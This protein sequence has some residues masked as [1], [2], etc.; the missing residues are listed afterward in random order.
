MYE[1]SVSMSSSSTWPKPDGGKGAGAAMAVDGGAPAAADSAARGAARARAEE[2]EAARQAAGLGL[3]APLDGAILSAVRLLPPVPRT[4]ARAVLLAHPLQHRQVTAV[5]RTVAS[6]RVPRA[7][8]RPRPE[9]RF[10]QPH[11]SS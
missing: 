5:R 4:I 6:E 7:A 10:Q 3:P 11:L 9:Y 8:L 1:R 2:R